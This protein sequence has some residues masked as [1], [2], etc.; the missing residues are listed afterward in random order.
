LQAPNVTGGNAAALNPYTF[1]ITYSDNVAIAGATVSAA[2]VEVLAP[3]ALA[4]VAA[5]IQSIT[6]VGTTDAI[7]DAQSFAVTYQI[8][9]PGGAWTAA[10]NGTYTVTLGGGSVTDLAGNAVAPGS[11]GTFSVVINGA[12]LTVDPKTLSFGLV[13]GDLDNKSIQPV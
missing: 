5:T 9:P 10:D 12:T 2:T 6:A 7:G 11:V 3:G 8:V 1:T 13:S 4:P